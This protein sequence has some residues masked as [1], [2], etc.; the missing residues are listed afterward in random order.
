MSLFDEVQVQD[1]C[2]RLLDSQTGKGCSLE[3]RH[4]RELKELLQAVGG[5]ES[6]GRSSRHI[7]T[8]AG[9]TYLTG[10][11]A[12]AAPPEP[13]KG[14]QLQRM[15]VSLPAR[16]NQAC[17]YALW[18]GDS[19]HPRSASLAAPQLAN[20]SLTQDEII[21][22]RTLEPLSL[23][24]RQGQQHD[25]T[26]MMALLGEL[27][28]PERALATLAA[29]DW[30]GERV[31][32][33]ENKGAFVDYPLQSG[34]LLLFA[35]GRNT[36]LAKRLIPLL[37]AGV[38]WAHFGDLDQRGIDIAIELA[39][40]LQRPA[41]LWL[42]CELQP[43]LEHYARPVRTFATDSGK[44]PWRVTKQADQGDGHGTPAGVPWLDKLITDGTWLEQEV[45]ILAPHWRSWS[46]DAM[47]NQ[48]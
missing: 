7:L 43:Y 35:P 1:L 20:L 29:I 39:R 22:I 21:R 26:A 24:D 17:F 4:G 12:R 42:P 28:L 34:Q 9:R 11:L 14:E 46:L 32:T 31:I 41:M 19:K 8:E 23:V 18:H 36:T 3:S 2:A 38:Q 13:D 30:Q 45:L 40:E 33:V 6:V 27:A 47:G 10:Q 25:M 44:V 48:V 37:P 16:L 15:G 5:V